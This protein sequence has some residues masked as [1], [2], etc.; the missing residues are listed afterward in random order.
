[1]TDTDQTRLT[2]RELYDRGDFK[3]ARAAARQNIES[4]K[5]SKEAKEDAT[6]I[7]QATGVDPIAVLVFAGTAV[8]LGYL[9]LRYLF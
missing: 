9:V 3:A 5:S 2:A 7:L 8:L 4:E 6:R 1:V